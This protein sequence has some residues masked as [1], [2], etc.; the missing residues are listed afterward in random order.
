MMEENVV[1]AAGTAYCVGREDM[2]HLIRD[3]GYIP[4]QRDTCYRV[5]RTF[6]EA[7]GKPEGTD[8]TPA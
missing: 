5:L 1:S 2:I 8:A 3:A 7:N 6:E 4:A